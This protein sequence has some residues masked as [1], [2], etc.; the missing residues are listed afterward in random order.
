MAEPDTT[1]V[2]VHRFAGRL[3]R[4]PDDVL[5]MYAAGWLPIAKKRAGVLT[6]TLKEIRRWEHRACPRRKP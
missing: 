5:R 6:W 4:G 1:I 3:G 2:G